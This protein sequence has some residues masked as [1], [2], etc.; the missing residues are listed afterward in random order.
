MSYNVRH[1]LSLVYDTFLSRNSIR[2]L[3]RV[4]TRYMLGH[5]KEGDR[6]G[7]HL[8]GGKDTRVLLAVLLG[9]D[10]KVSGCLTCDHQINHPN[11]LLEMCFSAF[12]IMTKY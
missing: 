9:N 10:V 11:Q 7:V 6:V 8:T 1:G 12:T 2:D 5:I 4:L 3:N